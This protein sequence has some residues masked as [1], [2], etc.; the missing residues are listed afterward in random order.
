MFIHVYYRVTK[1]YQ[2]LDEMLREMKFFSVVHFNFDNNNVKEILSLQSLKDNKLFN[3]DLSDFCIEDHFKK[4]I[5]GIKEHIFKEPDDT[6]A[7]QKR[8]KK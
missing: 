2:M 3:I 7:G 6:T 5:I 1:I 8:H 4:S